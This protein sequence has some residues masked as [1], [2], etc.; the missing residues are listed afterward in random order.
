MID[1]KQYKVVKG[2]DLIFR[3]VEIKDASFILS[4]RIDQNK[5]K[6]ISKVSNNLDDQIAWIQQ[7]QKANDQIYYLITDQNDH[8]IGTV[9][10]YNQ[11]ELSFEWGS[12]IIVDHVPSHYAIESAIMVYEIGMKLGFER[13]HCEVSKGNDSVIKFHERFG[14]KRV[15][16]DQ[17]Q[18]FYEISNE[19]IQKSLLRYHKFLPNGIQCDS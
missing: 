3:E 2:N 8:K 10:L 7:Y 12:W 18:N 5:S 6:F 11:K 19:A 14:A 1:F 9:R 13:A 17:I 15:N 4:L 16:E